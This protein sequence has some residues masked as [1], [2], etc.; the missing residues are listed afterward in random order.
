MALA[1]CLDVD[2]MPLGAKHRAELAIYKVLLSSQL[3]KQLQVKCRVVD[4]VLPLL[5]LK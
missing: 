2:Q 3:C 5:K 4:Q 1:D